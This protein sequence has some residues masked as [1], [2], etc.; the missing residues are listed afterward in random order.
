MSIVSLDQEKSLDEINKSLCYQYLVHFNSDLSTNYEQRLPE[1]AAL[2]ELHKR[3]LKD[4]RTNDTCNETNDKSNKSNNSCQQ[5]FDPII[6]LL[7]NKFCAGIDIYQ[8]SSPQNIPIYDL[9]ALLEGALSNN[10]YDFYCKILLVRLYNSLGAATSSHA[11]YETLDIKL[12]QNDTLGH[13]F[14]F[15]FLN[16]GLFSFAQQFLN[17]SWKFYSFNFK[18]VHRYLYI[19]YI[20]Y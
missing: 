1:L 4:L 19:L 18:E 12:I 13:Y 9:I 14:L 6:Y 16:A 8:T 3:T 5:P 11:L 20:F 2:Y 7:A 10:A 17:S 15:P